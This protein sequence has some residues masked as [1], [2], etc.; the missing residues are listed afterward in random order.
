M[1]RNIM[2]DENLEAHYHFTL[3]DMVDLIRTY[4]YS[5]VINDLDA[6]IA[7][8]VNNMTSNLNVD[9][10]PVIYEERN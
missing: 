2:P 8:Q 9:G 6:M 4:G 7:A 5:K 1:E 10:V 3:A